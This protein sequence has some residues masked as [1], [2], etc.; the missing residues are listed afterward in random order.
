MAARF[1]HAVF[2]ALGFEVILCF[3]ELDSGALMQVMHHFAGKIYVPIQAGADSSSAQS[4]FT[5][6]FEGYEKYLFAKEFTPF[7]MGDIVA[8]LRFD[9]FGTMAFAIF[10]LY[11]VRTLHLS[12]VPV[13]IVFAAGSVGAIVG[14]IVVNRV[15]RAIGVGLSIV[16]TG[17]VAVAFQPVKDRVDR[18][19]NRLVYGRR[20]TPY[21]RSLD[22]HISHLRKK[23][24]G[25]G[26]IR[27]IRGAGYQFAPAKAGEE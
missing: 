9:F 14:A 16:A 19:A 3:V 21:E 24:E 8:G 17:V 20:A 5:Q 22:V 6:D 12:S 1:H 18:L 23:L 27:T 26:S 25:A 7:F 4:E 15:Q 11:A 13:G 10:V 2:A